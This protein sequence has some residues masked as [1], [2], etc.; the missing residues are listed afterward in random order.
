MNKNILVFPCGSEIGLEINNALK[1][2]KN[3][4]LYGASSTNDH[5]RMVY[6]NYIELPYL[7]DKNFKQELKEAIEKYNIDYI[8]PAHDN[9][10][11]EF[12]RI[13]N[14][15][16]AEVITSEY[17][18]CDI[19]RSKRKTYEVFKTEKFTPHVYENIEEIKEYPIFVKPDIGQGSQRMCSCK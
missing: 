2:E 16:D 7:K 14:E 12:S 19:C 5:G 18:T 6:K 13:A 4:T 1:Y 10:V 8:F 9:L 17:L 3:I 15:L 11:L